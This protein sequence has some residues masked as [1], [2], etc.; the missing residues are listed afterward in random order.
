MLKAEI[1]SPETEPGKEMPAE[2]T[3]TLEEVAKEG[4]RDEATDLALYAKLSSMDGGKNP[5]AKEALA[6]LSRTDFTR[7]H[8]NW[9]IFLRSHLDGLPVGAGVAPRRIYEKITD[10]SHRAARYKNRC[11]KILVPKSQQGLFFKLRAVST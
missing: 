8:E 4:A 11:G 5:I 2:T 9:I 10:R 3:L 7:R 1:H 6:N